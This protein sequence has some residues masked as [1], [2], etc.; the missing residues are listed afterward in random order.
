[1]KILLTNDDGYSSEGIIL[2]KEELKKYGEVVLVAPKEVQSGRACALTINKNLSVDKIDEDTYVVDGTPIDCV[3]F[4]LSYIKDIDL[5]V[6]GC[7]DSPNLGVDTIYSGTC[8]ACS[9]GLIGKIKSIAFS[10]AS[11]KDFWQVS[12]FTSLALDY[13]FQNNLLSDQYF[14]NVNF[15]KGSF[16]DIKGIKITKLYYQNI[17]YDTKIYQ[18][19]QFLSTRTL[20]ESTQDLVFDR[21]CFNSG[22]I[23]ITPMGQNIFKEEIYNLLKESD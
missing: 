15:P 1:M 19:G 21:G 22:Y 11:K 12:K 16:V 23:S 8:G 10:C 9:Q 7:N 4:A 18:N 3:I 5:I 2:L 13:I 6:S 20:D 14:L 17:K